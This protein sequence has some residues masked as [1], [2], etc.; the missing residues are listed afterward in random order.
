MAYTI[1]PFAELERVLSKHQVNNIRR[2][3]GPDSPLSPGEKVRLGVACDQIG[4]DV[5]AEGLGEIKL[6]RGKATDAGVRFYIEPAYSRPALKEAVAISLLPQAKYP[7]AWRVSTG[8]G[9]TKAEVGPL[10]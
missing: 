10:D 2:L 7:Q 5:K 9:Q 6:V 3:L 1:D 4:R 8:G